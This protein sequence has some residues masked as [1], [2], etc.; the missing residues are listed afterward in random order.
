MQRTLTSNLP[1]PD[2]QHPRAITMLPA[3]AIASSQPERLD[4]AMHVTHT[5]QPFRSRTPRRL[6]ARQARIALVLLAVVTLALIAS[7]AVLSAGNWVIGALAVLVVVVATT[8]I[9][10]TLAV[11]RDFRRIASNDGWVYW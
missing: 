11:A 1:A 3:P 10:Y 5:V 7:A 2:A 9:G 6:S 8:L 4:T